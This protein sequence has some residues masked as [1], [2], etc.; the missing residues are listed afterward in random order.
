[1]NASTPLAAK[2]SLRDSVENQTPD[3]T[4]NPK[5]TR[6]KRRTQAERTA[7]SDARM[8]EAAKDL[9]VEQGTH[10]TTLKEVGERAGYSRGLASNRFGSKDALF[11]QL[12]LQFNNKWTQ[13]LAKAVGDRTGA[14]ACFAALHAVNGFLA[15]NSQYM[16]AMYILW[17]QSISSHDDARN[18]LSAY[19]AIYRR[20]VTHWVRE[21]IERGEIDRNV[22]ADC[23]AFQF[24][25]FIFGTIYQWLVAP[26]AVDLHKQFENFR[27]TTVREFGIKPDIIQ[28]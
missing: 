11:A 1:M 18:H 25:S 13:E 2:A 9:I 7:L 17:F 4:A 14:Q 28:S 26:D 15:N 27:L 8:F 5:S 23:Y 12:T 10:A 6:A 20:D 21:G 22:D 3:A 24:C 16:K 19:Q